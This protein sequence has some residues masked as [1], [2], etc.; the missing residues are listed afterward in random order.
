MLLMKAEFSA[1]MV[2]R[3][4]EDYPTVDI[5]QFELAT[6]GFDDF[7]QPAPRPIYTFSLSRSIYTRI[8][9]A[10][11]IPTNLD[12]VATTFAIS[13]DAQAELKKE[14]GS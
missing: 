13:A 3:F 9:W 4:Y 1:P 7:G 14:G 10:H 5:C 12:K 2:K 6:N 11:F 8:N